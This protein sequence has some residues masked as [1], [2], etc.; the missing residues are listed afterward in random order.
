MS[1]IFSEDVDFK[2]NPYQSV[3]EQE[4]E[5]KPVVLG[6]PS[7]G[8]PDPSTNSLHMLPVEDVEDR[9][10]DDYAQSVR[11]ATVLGTETTH[12]GE[13][14]SVTSDLDR[15]ISGKN[16]DSM[17]VEELKE[18]ASEREIEGR[19]EMNKKELVAALEAYDEAQ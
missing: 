3:E 9:V 14:D 7:Y 15:D 17:K 11:E 10:S 16:Y 4:M 1:G 2:P 5:M 8:S 13:P 19:S 12:P 18:L 6:P